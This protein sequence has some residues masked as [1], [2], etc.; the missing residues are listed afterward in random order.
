MSGRSGLGLSSA[1]TERMLRKGAL[2][3]VTSTTQNP[4]EGADPMLS[5]SNLAAVRGGR[6]VFRGVSF[7][8]APGVFAALRGPNGSGKTSLLR[9]LA[10]L[11]RAERGGATANGV[12]LG[13]APE[14]YREQVLLSGHLDAIK[15]SLTV[16][17]NLEFWLAYY[18]GDPAAV[19]PALRRFGI[20]HL[21][22]SPAGYCS[23]GQKRRLGLA[24]LAATRR[25]LWL[26]DEPTVS[27]D[28]ASID[29]LSSLI[30]E[31]CAGGGAVLAATH[32][33][34][35]V[36]ESQIIDMSRFVVSRQEAADETAEQGGETPSVGDDDDPFLGA[37]WEG[38]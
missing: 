22:E 15:P 30:A 26:L 21:A 5:V 16:A 32:A 14:L 13:E 34:F 4:T 28:A 36:A 6:R 27:L 33:P 29:A 18:G 37:A 12:A 20:D 7:D 9:V 10:G 3:T 17:E 25:P 35:S 38:R 31:H 2:T 24:R 19:A 11:A 1:W 23:A 8:V